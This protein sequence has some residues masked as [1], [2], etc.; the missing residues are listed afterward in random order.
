MCQAERV[1]AFVLVPILGYVEF[2]EAAHGLERRAPYGKV[3]RCSVVVAGDIHLL[4]I[5]IDCFEG[6]DRIR[7]FVLQCDANLAIDHWRGVSLGE[8]TGDGGDL[9]GIGDAIAIDK[10]KDCAACCRCLGILRGVGVGC[11]LDHDAET[12][13]RGNCYR[14]W[15]VRAVIGHDYFEWYIAR[16]LRI[17]IGKQVCKRFGLVQMW[18]DDVDFGGHDVAIRLWAFV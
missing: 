16:P 17:K 7:P 2:A 18:D 6:L 9:V 3:A 13:A 14:Q 5:V 8:M 1:G 11:W 4:V 10:C 12:L 15:A